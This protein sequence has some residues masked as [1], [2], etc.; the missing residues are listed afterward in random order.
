[1]NSKHSFFAAGL[2]AASIGIFPPIVGAVATIGSYSFLKGTPAEYFTDEDWTAYESAI[3]DALNN[4]KDGE[5]KTWQNP[6][7]QASGKLT[8]LKS[9]KTADKDCRLLKIAN[10]AKKRK[11]VSDQ[12]FCKQAD[13]QWKGAFI[14]DLKK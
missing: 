13:G 3:I 5:S 8:V 10:Q 7:S 12:L 9:L 1:M 2:L 11:R 14:E 6:N 4:S